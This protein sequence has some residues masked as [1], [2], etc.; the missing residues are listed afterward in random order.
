MLI[1]YVTIKWGKFGRA[2]C[3][4]FV[5][6]LVLPFVDFKMNKVEIARVVRVVQFWSEIKLTN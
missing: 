4:F 3:T 2:F 5:S 6:K 1:G